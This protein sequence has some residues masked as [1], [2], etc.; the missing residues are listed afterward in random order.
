MMQQKSHS[1]LHVVEQIGDISECYSAIDNEMARQLN[2]VLHDTH[3]ASL[4]IIDLMNALNSQAHQ[5]DINKHIADV[6][7]SMQSQDIL[8]QR[9]ERMLEVMKKRQTLFEKFVNQL[10]SNEEQLD[11]FGSEMNRLFRDY[12][13]NESRHANSIERHNNEQNLPKFELF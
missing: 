11:D 5:E 8:R 2:V 7:G 1:Y 4:V 6:L 10:Q 9:I 12:V 3:E 13:S